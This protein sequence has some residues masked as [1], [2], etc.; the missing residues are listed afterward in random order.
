MT[1]TAPLSTDREVKSKPPGVV[2]PPPRVLSVEECRERRR[3]GLSI[4]YGADFDL[5]VELAV[6][7]G[8]LDSE[9]SALQAPVWCQV[10]VERNEWFAFAVMGEAPGW[11]TTRRAVRAF[12]ERMHENSWTTLVKLL[13]DNG[14]LSAAGDWALGVQRSGPLQITDELLSGGGWLALLWE[15]FAPL[16]ADLK[17]LLGRVSA[18]TTDGSGTDVSD[19]V[20]AAVNEADWAAGDLR[21][22]IPEVHKGVRFNVERLEREAEKARLADRVALAKLGLS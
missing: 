5:M 16:S 17:V 7:C 1:S 3:V 9:V 14:A 10:G 13:V 15:R 19:S 18:R 4:H 12:S 2:L 20:K 8:S 11:A 6:I 22:L 21:R